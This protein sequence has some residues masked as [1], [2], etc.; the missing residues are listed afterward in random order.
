MQLVKLYTCIT[1]NL[2][3][4]ST[5]GINKIIFCVKV[6]K[7]IIGLFLFILKKGNCYDEIR[8]PTM[9]NSRRRT[10]GAEPWIEQVL[11]T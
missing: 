11:R 8:E 10:L 4:Y 7:K 5:A 3:L 9:Q 2:L 1:L 6:K